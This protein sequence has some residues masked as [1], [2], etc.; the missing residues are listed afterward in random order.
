M[1]AMVMTCI[2]AGAISILSMALG[3]LVRRSDRATSW[4]E[5]ETDSLRAEVRQ[6]DQDFRRIEEWA[7]STRAL[8]A[9]AHAMIEQVNL[10]ACD[11]IAPDSETRCTERGLHVGLHQTS[12]LTWYGLTWFTGPEPLTLAPTPWQTHEPLYAEGR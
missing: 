11:A 9:E 7:Q 1:N 2:G 4:L 5:A 6:L 3:W 10:T 8:W 12:D